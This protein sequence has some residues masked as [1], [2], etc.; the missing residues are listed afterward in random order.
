VSLA[1][2]IYDK[3]FRIDDFMAEVAAR[4]SAD[5]VRVRGLVQENFGDD[6][7]STVMIL[8][9]LAS[10]GRI[11]ISQDLGNH[12]QG[13]RLDPHGLA[14]AGGRIDHEIAGGVDLV[15][16]NKFGKAEAEQGAGLRSTVARAIESGVPVLTAV[17]AP[18][19]DAWDAFHGGM[20]T[21]LAPELEAVLAWCRAAAAERRSGRNTAA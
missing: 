4:L 15:V 7:N 6:P 8:V 14:D 16:L 5:G 2:I 3:G 11:G 9:D 21:A 10:S 20:S 12:A 17:R 19:T 13:C 1:A 18:Y